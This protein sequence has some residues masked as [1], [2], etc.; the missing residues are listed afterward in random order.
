MSSDTESGKMRR[1]ACR[2]DS[3][4]STLKECTKRQ[5][6]EENLYLCCADE[7]L[8]EQAGNLQKTFDRAE[9][10][11]NS[12]A[13]DY[14]ASHEVDSRGQDDYEHHSADEDEQIA[15]HAS[16]DSSSDGDSVNCPVCSVTITTQEAGTPDTCDHTFCAACLQKWS[17]N[18]NTCPVDRQVFKS[19]IVR[20]HL[21]GEVIT[22]I[23][24][25][26]PLLQC[27]CDCQTSHPWYIRLADLAIYGLTFWVVWRLMDTYFPR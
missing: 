3:D 1:A 6:Y 17:E 7:S 26:P 9:V 15:A 2:R 27:E 25:E 13:G 24:V 18:N 22:R 16:A 12:A 10:N 5:Q 14:P 20:R 11:P 4:D 21:Q 19:K 23:P 8:L